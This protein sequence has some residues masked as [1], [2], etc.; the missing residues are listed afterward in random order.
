MKR[1][2]VEYGRG[3]VFYLVVTIRKLRQTHS[4]PLQEHIHPKDLPDYFL[5]NCRLSPVAWLLSDRNYE[6]TLW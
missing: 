5:N 3:L 1:E 2:G 4:F 6:L